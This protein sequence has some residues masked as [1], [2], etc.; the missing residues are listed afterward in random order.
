MKTG[1]NDQCPCG[2]GKK[3]KKCCSGKN[4]QTGEKLTISTDELLKIIH[5]GLENL[6][7]LAPKLKSIRVKN[8]SL[9]SV[10]TILCEFYSNFTRAL[11][12]KQEIGPLI[13]FLSGLLKDDIYKD[14]KINYFAV[15]AY[16]D[17]DTELLFAI[18]TRAA[19]TAAG[20]GNSIEWLKNT[21]FQENTPDYRLSRAKTFVSDI[22]NSLRKVIKDIY[23]EKY[24]NNW[25]DLRIEKTI[26]KSVKSTFTNQ[27]G[28]T[29]TEG[30]ALI[31]YTFTLDLKKIVSADWGAFK[32]LFNKKTEFE[33][34][35]VRLNEIRREEAHNREITEH[36]L[37]DLEGI[38][39]FLLSEIV[40]LYPSIDLSY[41]VEHWRSKIKLI[42]VY[43]NHIDPI[44]S[45]E[46]FE[47]SSD[48]EK[49]RLMIAD[50]TSQIN[51]VDKLVSDLHSISPPI[52]KKR[53]H[54][55]LSEILVQYGELQRQ[56]REC[57]QNMDNDRVP[58]ILSAIQTQI[59]LMNCFVNDFLLSES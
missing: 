56:K 43:E 42:L 51:F 37:K 18:S 5:F 1:R 48:E 11:E 46:E 14:I 38:Y 59:Q 52:S 47:R 17:N 6:A 22:E 28:E 53:K 4:C 7:T 39:D 50:S 35:M 26:D 12:V 58:E 19:A 3:Y 21:Y 8:V 32:H 24:G 41:L 34:K 31:N 49:R 25:W 23:K 20:E 40:L 44:Y 13:G 29:T 30:D 57:V 45:A 15:K 16:S 9:S 2:S 27:F 55:E 33:S 36:H 10:N 54:L